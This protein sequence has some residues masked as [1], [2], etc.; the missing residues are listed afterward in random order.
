MVIGL[1]GLVLRG[2][3]GVGGCVVGENIIWCS[4]GAT[5]PHPSVLS[6]RGGEALPPPSSLTPDALAS[7]GIIAGVLFLY[8]RTH[9][10]YLYF[11]S[12]CVQL[13]VLRGLTPHRTLSDIIARDYCALEI[14]LVYFLGTV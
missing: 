6:A 14:R 7:R 2:G 13:P 12:A 11:S 3:R 9:Y 1:G 10:N 8:E 4:S 5:K